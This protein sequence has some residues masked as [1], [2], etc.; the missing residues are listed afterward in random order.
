MK[1]GRTAS[2]RERATLRMTQVPQS[3]TRLRLFCHLLLSFEL[4]YRYLVRC[5][6]FL[7]LSFV[8]S[9]SPPLILVLCALPASRAERVD[10]VSRA[11][12]RTF[13]K[14]AL[15]RERAAF[16]ESH[17]GRV[18]LGASTDDRG[19][20]LF[21]REIFRSRITRSARICVSRTGA[22]L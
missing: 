6:P 2:V 9:P 3:L 18:P 20:F 11:T 12:S 10:G 17:R 8:A 7:P 14:I 15:P 19:G 5:P 13:F 16:C 1:G 22:M 21:S 4:F